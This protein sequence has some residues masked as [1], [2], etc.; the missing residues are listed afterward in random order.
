MQGL[1]LVVATSRSCASVLV[2]LQRDDVFV[3]RIIFHDFFLSRRL[4]S[5][6]ESVARSIDLEVTRTAQEFVHHPYRSLFCYRDILN[7]CAPLRQHQRDFLPTCS[8][9]VAVW[10]SSSSVL[11]H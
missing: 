9:F 6:F 2:V 4:V 10:R 11:R 7:F 3:G 1:V 5:Q 8:A